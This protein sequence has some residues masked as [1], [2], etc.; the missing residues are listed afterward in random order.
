MAD[1]VYVSMNGA[2]ARLAQLESLS[3]NLANVQTPG[4][5]A[6]RPAF[7][8]FLSRQGSRET[9]LAYPA[10]VGTA[11]DLRPGAIMRTNEPLDLVPQGDA[12]LAVAAPNGLAY[13]RNGHLVVDV[14]GRLTSGGH[15]V[16]GHDAQPIIAPQGTV[17][18]IEPS[19]TVY[20]DNAPIGRIATFSFTGPID[21]VGPALLVP[22]R[23]EQVIEI[24]QGVRLGELELGNS[25]ALETTVQ[26][27]SAQRA[28]DA[29][30][31]A[32][33]TSRRLD[34]RVSEVGRV[35]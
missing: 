17:V 11:L 2:A 5:K 12:Y 34:E 8:A 7:E 1:G 32:L 21:K 30:M 4:F 20:A 3:D 35:R 25:S 10:A 14:A 33:T 15:P 27:V 16:L 6:T 24:G 9:A 23:P 28:F 29:A 13:T 18:R 26:L 31:Q 19:G 22:E